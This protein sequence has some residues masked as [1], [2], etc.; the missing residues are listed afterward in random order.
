MLFG[1]WYPA[2]LS[3]DLRAGAIRAATAIRA[4]GR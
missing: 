1:L 4:S 3:R 2:M